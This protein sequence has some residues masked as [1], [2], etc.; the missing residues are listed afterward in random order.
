MTTTPTNG[1][2][3]PTDPGGEPVDLNKVRA[4]RNPAAA[5]PQLYRS[6]A[7]VAR[8]P[9]VG[10]DGLGRPVCA[11]GKNGTFAAHGPSTGSDP[12]RYYSC[13]DVL[14]IKA[15]IASHTAAARPSSALRTRVAGLVT[16]LRGL[17][18]QVSRRLEV[19]TDD[20]QQ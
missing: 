3:P 17:L 7:E 12:D 13:A 5:A 2:A 16:R 6:A 8:Y 10:K 19:D 18:E 14:D 11:C 9:Y 20:H 1:A 15:S 4:Q